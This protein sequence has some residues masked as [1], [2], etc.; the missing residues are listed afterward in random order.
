MF[1]PSLKNE[2]QEYCTSRTW[3]YPVYDLLEVDP[4]FLVRVKVTRDDGT[5]LTADGFGPRKKCAEKAAAGN[6]LL[7]LQAAKLE[8]DGVSS[9]PEGTTEVPMDETQGATPLLNQ[10]TSVPPSSGKNY[11]SSLSEYCQHHG[12][13]PPKY[14]QM[15][16]TDAPHRFLM[17]LTVEDKQALGRGSNKKEANEEAAK[18]MWNLIEQENSIPLNGAPLDHYKIINPDPEIGV[19]EANSNPPIPIADGDTLSVGKFNPV[20]D[21]TSTKSV[22]IA[23]NY[24]E[25]LEK[26]LKDANS[27]MKISFVPIPTEGLTTDEIFL[28]IN[29]GKLDATPFKTGHGKGVTEVEARNAA[30]YNVIQLLPDEFKP[31]KQNKREE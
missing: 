20:R 30:A 22:P 8:P 12:W 9:I 10:S 17:Q 11:R 27:E 21:Q 15:E 6:L 13:K 25:V 24:V 26:M 4:E 29:I 5:V 23:T 28:F 18:N 31:N 3:R 2:L 1:A 16:S 7:K 19:L 14:E